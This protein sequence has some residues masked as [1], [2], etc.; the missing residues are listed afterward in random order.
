MK[1]RDTMSWL[2]GAMAGAAA[3]YLLDP[4]TGARRRKYLKQHAEEYLENAGDALGSGWE[5]VSGKAREIG[6]TVADTAQDYG[7]RLADQAKD[8]GSSW[9]RRAGS[10]ASDLSDQASG[11]LSRG[12]KWLSS[13]RGQA[14]DYIPST[15]QMKRD[16][17]DYGQGLWERTR[18]RV[19]K[20]TGEDSSPVIPVVLTA[21]GCC[22]LGAGLMYVIDPQRGRS[23]RAWLMDKTQSIFRRTGRS[24]YRGGKD[25]ANRAYG[26][27]HELGGRW[28]QRSSSSNQLSERVRSEMGRAISHPRLVEVMCD[29]KGTITLSGC[30]IESEAAPLIERIENM[31]GVNLVVSRLESVATLED[32]DRRAGSR[33]QRASQM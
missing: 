9:S 22:A 1:T 31:P 24:M 8:L 25:M 33:T 15:R 7:H 5:M 20:M 19:H 21:V 32:L 30:V 28:Q 18:G 29:D 10:T 4:D 17:R 6:G 27:A 14:K 2:F 11:W 13:H 3:M 26:A 23:R 12:G 16:L